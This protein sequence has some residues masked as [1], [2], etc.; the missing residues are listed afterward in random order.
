FGGVPSLWSAML[1]LIEQGDAVRP[2]GLVAVLLGG[3]ALPD[4]VAERTFALFPDVALWNHYGPTEATVNTSV[5][6]VRP[7]ERVN[8]GRPVANARVYLLDEH[9]GPVPAGIPGELYV[10]GA[11]ISRGYLGRPSLTAE[12][13]LP[14]PFSPTPGARMYRSGDRV[15]W[16]VSQADESA[17]TTA[18]SPP[19]RTAEAGS[20]HDARTAALPHSR[21]AFL[22]Y[23]GR[24]DHQVKV[25]GFRI[26][27][28]EIEAALRREAGVREAVVVA[29][30]DTPGDRRLVA[31]VAGEVE[32]DALRESLRRTL[33]DYMIPAAFVVL[34]EIPRTPRGKVDRAALPAPD[35]AAAEDGFAAPRTPVEEVLAAIW[36]DVL[37]RERVG[38]DEDFF[39][40]G[41]HSLLATVV[42]GLIRQA[43]AVEMPLRTFFEGSTVAELA[44]AV[45]TLRRAAL[46]TLPPVVPVERQGPPPL[47]FAQ[48]RLWFLD[49]LEPGN[50][51]YN[52]ATV[53]RLEGALDAA[54]MERALGEVVRR[55]DVLRTT[56]RQVDGVPV[57][58]VSP[59]AGFA[60][61]VEELAH[62]PEPERIATFRRRSREEAGRPFD[63]AA[64]PLIRGR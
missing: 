6:R 12:R 8:I 41:G 47:S 2:A 29:R 64:G 54:A 37:D 56:F 32:V 49:Q 61:P 58:E 9:G 13:Y 14:D 63:L 42:V 33:P 30:E 46:P 7:G 3:E 1:A 55:H 53:L 60:L 20:A 23:V 28:G 31:Y 17:A 51:F 35:Y 44:Q 4:E 18:Q 15:R 57:Q 10:A 40:I 59:F 24:V 36:A 19:S 22:E 16:V 39:E 11:G 5:A 26:E 43:F 45:E 21:T 62:L 48:E 34:E 25:R 38:V 52:V 27:P 50:S